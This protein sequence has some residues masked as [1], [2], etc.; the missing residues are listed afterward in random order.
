MSHVTPGCPF[1]CPTLWEPNGSILPLVVGFFSELLT[2]AGVYFPFNRRSFRYHVITSSFMCRS[3]GRCL[4]INLSYHT[5]FS[6]FISSLF[7]NTT[8]PYWL[9][10]SYS[11]TPFTVLVWSYH[12]WLKY[13]FVL[14][15]LLKWMYNNPWHISGYCCSYC[16]GKWNTCSEGGLPPFLSPHLTT[17]GYFN[18]RKWLPYLDGHC[19]CR[20]NSHKYGVVSI[21]DDNTCS[22]NGC[23]K[24]DTILHRT[25]TRRWLHSPCYWNI[26]VFSFLFWFI[27]NH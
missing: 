19:H 7:Y 18:Y 9:A 8:Y 3:K 25:S 23:S 2:E 20:P 24:E 6:S 1:S 22:D 26:W 15:P 11:Y 13:P 17:N 4:V 5:S 12:W 14:V 16:F 27:F 21:D 10:T